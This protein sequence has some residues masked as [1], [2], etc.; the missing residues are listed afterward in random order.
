MAVNVKKDF[1][2]SRSRKPDLNTL[3]YGKIPPQ[4]PELEE[5]VLGALMLEKEKYEEVATILH[6][7]DCFY[8]DAHQKI[9][10]A[11]QTLKINGN[12]VDLLTVTEQLR[13]QNELEIVGGAHFLT[14]L[15]MKVVSSAHVEAHAYLIKEKFIQRELIRISGQVIGDAY[16]DATDAF[17]LIAK[18]EKELYDLNGNIYTTESQHISKAVAKSQIWLE[19]QL[20]RDEDITGYRTGFKELDKITGGLQPTNVIVLAARPAVGKTAFLLN[21]ALNLAEDGIP[22][23]IFS[24]EMSTGQNMRRMYSIKGGI[25][26]EYWKNPK[27]MPESLKNNLYADIMP[28]VGKLPIYIDDKTH[29]SSTELTSKAKKLKRKYGVKVV[30]IDYLQLMAGDAEKGANRE[31]EISKISRD[32]KALAKDEE[33]VVIELSQLN[34]AVESRQGKNK[35]VPM[36]SDLRESGSIEQDADVVAFL[37][38]PPEEEIA[39]DVSLHDLVYLE[40]AKNRDGACEPIQL[41]FKRESQQYRDRFEPFSS[42]AGMPTRIPDNYF[43]T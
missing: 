37:Y 33:L 17:D 22:V 4:A 20:A 25:N 32:M 38:R 19:E 29:I 21:L 24:L 5:A 14:V 42:N 8:V 1:G 43:N 28:K 23:A 36:L 34:R 10:S 11:I 6:T 18:L 31:R 39:Q 26:M 15:T 41:T 16:E 27:A 13:K 40:L 12:S 9:F 7:P 3:V 2:N 30:L 35:G